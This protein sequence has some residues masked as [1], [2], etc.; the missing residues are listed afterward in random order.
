M[1]RDHE[2][3][4]L[5][6][7]AQQGDP[8]AFAVLYQRFA[9]PLFHF[10][11]AHCRDHTLTEDL[12]A[13]LWLRVVETLPTFYFPAGASPAAF[14]GWLYRIARNLLVDASRQAHH[15][16]PLVPTLHAAEP[17]AEELVLRREGHQDLQW[18]L[19]QL[20][21][22]QREVLL[23]RFGAGWSWA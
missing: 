18:A 19:H 14:A 4:G 11:Y 13:D 21:A 9:D 5:V 8:Q 12:T 7:R 6:T 3:V 2:I 23:L 1:T 10:C 16:A 20:T 15:C 17:P 22:A